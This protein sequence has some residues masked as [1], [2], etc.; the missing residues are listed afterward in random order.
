MTRKITVIN[1]QVLVDLF[2]DIEKDWI[3]GHGLPG[4]TKIVGYDFALVG[5]QPCVR[6]ALES[7]SWDA[8]KAGEP[9]EEVALTISSRTEDSF[10]V[11]EEAT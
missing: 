7:E 2:K 4:D 5:D 10:E 11:P 1:I 8:Q 3:K 9:V 6:L